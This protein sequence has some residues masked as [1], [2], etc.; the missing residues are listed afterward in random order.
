MQ[1]LESVIIELKKA[2]AVDQER[3]IVP[4]PSMAAAAHAFSDEF[5]ATEDVVNFIDHLEVQRAT[6]LEMPTRKVPYYAVIQSSG[7]GKS[8][9]L[10][11]LMEGPSILITKRKSKT[12]GLKSRPRT[13]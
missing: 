12:L 5:I 3:S 10:I 7:Y 11:G 2:E 6:Y 8:R 13:N 4:Y 9:L 1:M